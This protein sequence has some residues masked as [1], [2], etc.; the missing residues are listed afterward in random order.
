MAI[1]LG[2][3]GAAPPFGTSIISATYTEECEVIDVTNRDN[4]GSSGT[5]P[6]FRQNKAGFQSRTWEIEC[7]DASGLVTALETNSAT[8]DYIVTGI[9][10]NVSIDGA[11]T[12][13][14]TA[15]EGGL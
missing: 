8:S 9:T 7:H 1:A 12:Y 14:V 15:R 5:S 6:G 2:K 3:A 13:T 4:N 10:E 11:V